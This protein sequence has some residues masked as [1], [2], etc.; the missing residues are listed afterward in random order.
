MGA[1]DAEHARIAVEEAIRVAN[2][3]EYGLSSAVF[4]RDMQRALAVAKRLESG[5][6]HIN[7][8]TVRD[9]GQMPFSGVGASGSG[10]SGG[11]AVIA[12]FTEPRWIAIE[13]PQAHPF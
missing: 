12:E 7:G 1:R 8:P 6:C 9:E 13:G 11:K 4:S 10:R 2:D 3:T 5:I